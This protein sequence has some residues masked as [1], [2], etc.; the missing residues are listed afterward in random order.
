VREGK[1]DYDGQLAV[2]HAVLRP[3]PVRPTGPPILIA[4]GRPRM[5]GLAARWAD[6]WNS[7]WY[8]HPTDEFRSERALLH[9]SCE[10]IGRDPSSVEVTVGLVIA[11][12]QSIAGSWQQ[13]IPDRV[14][15]VAAALRTWHAEGVGEVM[16]RMEAPAIGMVETV[17]RATQLFRAEVPI[18]R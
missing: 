3:P 9:E 7:V 2:G 5:M 4:A 15:D 12:E 13:G 1:V 10:R 18:S 11:D 16:F 8:G 6:R 17:G 14:E